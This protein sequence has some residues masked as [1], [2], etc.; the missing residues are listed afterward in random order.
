MSARAYEAFL[1]RLYVDAEARARFERDPE[2]EGRRAGLGADECRALADIDRLGLELAAA[3]YAWKRQYAAAAARNGRGLVGR[4]VSV[5]RG[6]YS[7][8]SRTRSTRITES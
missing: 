5:L 3:S 2:G 6:R 4:L 8:T 7:A 1:A